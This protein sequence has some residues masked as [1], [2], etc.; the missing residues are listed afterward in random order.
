MRGYSG[1]PTYACLLLSFQPLLKVKVSLR[2]LLLLSLAQHGRGDT[3]AET[4]GSS[5]AKRM[6]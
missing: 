4:F 5:L 2:F 1:G 3:G 6:K